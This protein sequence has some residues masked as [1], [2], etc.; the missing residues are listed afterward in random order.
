MSD[1]DSKTSTETVEIVAKQKKHFYYIK[2]MYIVEGFYLPIF[3][4]FRIALFLTF[5]TE[6]N[7]HEIARPHI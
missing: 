1:D 6:L 3:L 5:T 7:G 2:S 4:S